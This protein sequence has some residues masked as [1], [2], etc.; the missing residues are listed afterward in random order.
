VEVFTTRPDTIFGV[1]FMTLAPEHELVEDH[2]RRTKAEVLAYIAKA[3]NRSDRDRMA[4]VKNGERRVHRCVRADHP[5][6]GAEVPVWVGDYVL[7]RL[8]HRCGDG[9]ARRRPARLELRHALR[10]AHHRVTKVRRSAKRPM[11]ARMPSSAAKA[12]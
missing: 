2:H 12:S 4:D 8:W 7:A 1:S 9:R 11:N 10:T 5:F 3:K 6:T